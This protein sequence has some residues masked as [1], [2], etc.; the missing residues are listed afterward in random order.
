[1]IKNSRVLFL[2]AVG[3]AIFLVSMTAALAEDLSA[4]AFEKAIRQEMQ[5]SLNTNTTAD[6][7]SNEITWLKAR[8]KE[9]SAV[10][11]NER[12]LYKKTGNSV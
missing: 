12:D 10:A 2:A 8:I 1:M 7:T 6:N 11:K 4:A 3:L 9:L 5:K